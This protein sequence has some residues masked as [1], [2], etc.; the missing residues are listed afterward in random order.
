MFSPYITVASPFK[1]AASLNEI[2]GVFSAMSNDD[3]YLT[4]VMIF[5]IR[6]RIYNDGF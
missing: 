4:K 6:F 2:I 1:I 3:F 5:M